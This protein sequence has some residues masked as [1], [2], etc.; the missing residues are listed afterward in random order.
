MGVKGYGLWVMGY[1]VRVEERRPEYRKSIGVDIDI[2][3]GMECIEGSLL[4]FDP[5][6]EVMVWEG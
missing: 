6:A 3:N 2:Y 4:Y 5:E 1:V